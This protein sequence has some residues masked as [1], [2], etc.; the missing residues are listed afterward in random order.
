MKRAA[1]ARALARNGG[2]SAEGRCPQPHVKL[3]VLGSVRLAVCGQPAPAGESCQ[4]LLVMLAL[5][6][7]Q[8]NRV[9]AAGLLWPEVSTGR[10]NANL[11]SVI[12][13]LQRCCENAVSATFS[14]VYL[15]PDVTVDLDEV[16]EVAGTL[17]DR[18]ADMDA[19]ALKRAL[20]CNFFDDIAPGLYDWEWLEVERD[21]HR[22]LRL[23]AMEALSEQLV[24]AGW[25]GAAVD[26][27]LGAVRADAYRESAQQQLI[28]AYLAEG[29]RLEARRRYDAYRNLLRKEL[30]LEPSEQFLRL[31][32]GTGM[33]PAR[34]LDVVRPRRSG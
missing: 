1:V 8:V 25:Y 7:R 13:R 27:A 28:R 2:G 10:A 31:L 9:H 14:D 23:H 19:E 20:N 29:N 11:R 18:S 33:A 4:R 24:K 17:L 5:K 6:N 32:N 21:R 30:D 3:S 22:Q 34:G 15:M 26:S 12:W 16:S